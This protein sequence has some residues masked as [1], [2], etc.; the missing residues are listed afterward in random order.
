[1]GSW[2]NQPPLCLSAPLP[3]ATS[4]GAAPWPT[5]GNRAPASR[6][7]AHVHACNTALWMETLNTRGDVHEQPPCACRVRAYHG[8]P[9]PAAAHPRPRRPRAAARLRWRWRACCTTCRGA[10]P[11]PRRAWR[12]AAASRTASS[13]RPARPTL[14]LSFASSIPSPPP[15]P[16]ITLAR[17]LFRLVSEAPHPRPAFPPRVP[18][19]TP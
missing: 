13:R 9:A 15:P 2:G 19:P 17:A 8:P 16:P 11:M 10:R 7:R 3:P 6:T 14:S 4:A 1:M 5:R 12:P 18:P